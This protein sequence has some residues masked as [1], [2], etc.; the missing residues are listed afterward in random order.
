VH[1]IVNDVRRY[2]LAKVK[3]IPVKQARESNDLEKNDV[4]DANQILVPLFP[5]MQE[6]KQDVVGFLVSMSCGHNGKPQDLEATLLTIHLDMAG[7]MTVRAAETVT[8][9]TQ[10]ISMN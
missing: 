4:A 9:N 1:S 8:Y 6:P 2:F 10:S 5:T 3:R 7:F